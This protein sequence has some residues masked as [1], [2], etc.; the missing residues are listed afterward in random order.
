MTP[1]ER[2]AMAL[3]HAHSAVRSDLGLETNWLMTDGL[4]RAKYTRDARAVLEA[5]REAS[6]EMLDAGEKLR[7]SGPARDVSAQ[8]WQVMIDTAL[9]GR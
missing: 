7:L 5:V 8:T 4:T 1:I 2:A 3:F 9:K 6:A